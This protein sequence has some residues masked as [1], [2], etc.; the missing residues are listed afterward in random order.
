[1]NTHGIRDILTFNGADF[2]RFPNITVID[3]HS[4]TVS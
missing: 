4:F 2:R 3:P 1:M